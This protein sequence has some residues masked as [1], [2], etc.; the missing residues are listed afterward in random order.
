MQLVPGALSPG[1][2]RHGCEGDHSPPSSAEVKKGGAL[3]PLPHVFFMTRCSTNEE[4]GQLYF[5]F[6]FLIMRHFRAVSAKVACTGSRVQLSF[7]A[8]APILLNA[9]QSHFV[10]MK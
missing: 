2:E 4:Q 3:P 8:S 7:Y 10:S 5:T 6:I 9:F 1:V